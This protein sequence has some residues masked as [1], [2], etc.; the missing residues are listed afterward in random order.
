MLRTSGE[1]LA[2]VMS[3][4]IKLAE[5]FVGI[6]SGEWVLSCR[7]NGGGVVFVRAAFS[8]AV[9]YVIAL[10]F[11]SYFQASSALSFDWGE[12]KRLLGTHPSWL[13]TFFAAA[14]AALYARFSA[15]WTYLAGLYNQLMAAEGKDPTATLTGAC[16]ERRQRWWHAFIEDAVELHLAS[17]TSYATV[18]ANRLKEKRISDMFEE[19]D[20][21]GKTRLNRLKRRLEGK[22]PWQAPTS[23]DPAVDPPTASTTRE[24]LQLLGR[25]PTYT[26][27]MHFMAWAAKEDGKRDV[28]A[29]VQRLP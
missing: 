8:A 24:W 29:A 17:K 21:A 26:E 9:S 19:S 14:Y 15:Q 27:V 11:E 20:K 22:W 28:Y 7:P 16:L 13:G 12:L 2:T 10:G 6:L 25:A 4:P 5:W 23:G 18:I 1:L 3:F